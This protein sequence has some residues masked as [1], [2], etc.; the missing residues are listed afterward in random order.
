MSSKS[1]GPGSGRHFG[2]F[3]VNDEFRL[4]KNLQAVLGNIQTSGSGSRPPIGVINHDFYSQSFYREKE[5][6]C[7][8]PKE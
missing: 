1:R 6:H 8:H 3:V 2:A 7:G 4:K 5:K